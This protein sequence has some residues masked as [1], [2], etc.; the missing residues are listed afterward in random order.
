[1]FIFLNF[2]GALSH[3]MLYLVLSETKINDS[4]STEQFHVEDYEIRVRRDQNK[5]RESL[6]Q[7]AQEVLTCKRLK[8]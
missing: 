6:I 1:M 5:C 4:L 2:H 7:V 3:Q 8:Q